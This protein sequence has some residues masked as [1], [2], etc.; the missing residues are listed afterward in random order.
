MASTKTEDK[1]PN[2]SESK[3]DKKDKNKIKSSTKSQDSEKLDSL[4]SSMSEMKGNLSQLASDFYG[5]DEISHVQPKRTLKFPCLSSNHGY[6]DQA[7]DW[8]QNY[9]DYEDDM[10]DDH[11]DMYSHDYNYDQFNDG[12]EPYE[13]D[14]DYDDENYYEEE[15]ATEGDIETV[16]PSTST[17]KDRKCIRLDNEHDEE[18]ETPLPVVDKEIDA[19][20]AEYELTKP[21]VLKD[22]T[23]DP[24]PQP[25]A[26]TLETWFWK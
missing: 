12:F 26:D 2:K 24:M 10:Y 9:H 25:L 3:T 14:W 11:E 16:T 19:I 20:A 23:T 5:T 22:S 7:G 4:L 1:T 17:P 15:T 21:R 8:R 6:D 18:T 13:D